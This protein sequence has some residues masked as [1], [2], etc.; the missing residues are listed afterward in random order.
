MN[1]QIDPT[2]LIDIEL[3]NLLKYCYNLTKLKDNDDYQEE[4]I[5]KSIELGKKN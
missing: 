5:M 3:I 4:L 2:K 1:Q